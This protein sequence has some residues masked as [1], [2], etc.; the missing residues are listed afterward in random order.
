MINRKDGG[1][2]AK[3]I[4]E[5][6]GEGSK[7]VSSKDIAVIDDILKAAGF[8]GAIAAGL[9]S[10]PENKKS[11]SEVP[12]HRRNNAKG[13]VASYRRGGVERAGEE[14]SRLSVSMEKQEDAGFSPSKAD[15]REQHKLALEG[16][17]DVGADVTIVQ[18]HDSREQL[19]ETDGVRGGGAA[20]RGKN[21]S[22]VS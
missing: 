18:G 1:V 16:V 9:E 13:G 10:A 17:M 8:E 3:M 11:K 12:P 7:N 2:A 19:G 4:R 20:I 15:F 14:G 5:L 21:F 6:L 22:G